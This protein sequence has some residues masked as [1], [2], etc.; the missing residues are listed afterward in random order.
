MLQILR[1]KA[2]STI[3]QALV[4]II[5]LVFIFWGVG[6]NLM[7]RRDA[8]IVVNDQEIPFQ[9]FQK[10]YDQMVNAYRQQ[11]GDAIS[12]EMLKGLGVK[13]Q[14]I[15]QLTQGELLRQGSAAMGIMVAPIEI[16]SS[17]KKMPQFQSE[18]G[19]DLGKYKAILAAN[20]FSPHKFEDSISQDLLNDKGLL[21]INDFATTVSDSEISALHRQDQESVVVKVI[22]IKPGA[23][24]EQIVVEPEALAAWFATK[25]EN[26]KGEQKIKL[27]YLSFPFKS[28][29]AGITISDEQVQ[30]QFEKDKADYQTPEQRQARHILLK[31]SADSS[32]DQKAAQRKKADDILV[33]ARAGEDFAALAT[34]WSEDTSKANGGD[35]GTFARG[36][37]VKEFEDAAFALEQGAISEVVTTPFGYHIIKV[38]KIHPAISRTLEEVRPALVTKLQGEQAKPAAFQVANSA[39]EGIISAGSLQAYG[40]K[41]SATTIGS[42][43]FFSRSAPPAGMERDPRFLDTIFALKQGELSSLI[44]TPSGYFIV[45]A[46]AIQESAHPQLEEVMEQVKKDYI[47][48]QSQEKAK[49]TA[50]RLFTAIQGGGDFETVAK[51]ANLTVTTTGPLRKKSPQP[52]PALPASLVDQ[53]LLLSA[54]NPLPKEALAVQDNWYLLSFVE[55]TVPELASLKDETRKEYTATL[56]KQKQD[57]LLGSWLKQQEKRSKILTSKNL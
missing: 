38:E 51:E 22:A 11:F 39:Y 6:T 37:M 48:A 15:S 4:L 55:R 34:T 27:K 49:E 9:E 5:A 29:M 17:I 26:Y 2:Q 1:N 42:T 31:T 12:E 35:L 40:E 47:V 7:N 25:K 16:Q 21:F 23:F 30:A 8:A 3:I 45:F 41:N 57:R 19:F 18:S 33:K 14:V 24:N 36:R 44:E 28:Q 50:A 54:K 43:E 46:E 32:P 53:A 13:Q 10:R 56:L 52:D 20:S